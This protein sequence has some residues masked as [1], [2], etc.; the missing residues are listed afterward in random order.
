MTWRGA[1]AGV[2]DVKERL[3]QGYQAGDKNFRVHLDWYNCAPFLKGEVEK[4]PRQSIIYFSQGGELNAVRFND[5]KIHFAMQKGPL[6]TR[7]E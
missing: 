3:P 7:V 5:W 4:G 6:D 1:P 2:P